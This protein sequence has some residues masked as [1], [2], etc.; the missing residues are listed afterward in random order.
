V[1]FLRQLGNAGEELECDESMQLI[2]RN[3]GERRAASAAAS[4]LRVVDKSI[5]ERLHELGNVTFGVDWPVTNRSRGS[6]EWWAN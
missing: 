6:E 1:L 4:A 3:A 2:R 5:E